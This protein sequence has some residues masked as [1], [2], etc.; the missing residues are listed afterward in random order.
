ME[1]VPTPPPPTRESNWNSLPVDRNSETS[2]A[3]QSREEAEPCLEEE[4]RDYTF[5]ILEGIRKPS[6]LEIS[7]RGQKWSDANTHRPLG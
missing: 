3:V 5:P 6:Q 2:V 1:H 4:I 7:L